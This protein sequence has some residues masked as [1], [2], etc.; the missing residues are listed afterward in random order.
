MPPQPAAV[1]RAARPQRRR[2]QQPPRWLLP[3]QHPQMM[4]YAGSTARRCRT[5]APS[6]RRQGLRHRALQRCP[7]RRRS[8][9]RRP[10]RPLCQQR[11]RV[12]RPRRRRRCGRRFR[13]SPPRRA[14]L[15]TRRR[16]RRWWPRHHSRPPIATRRR[17]HPGWQH[18][19]AASCEQH[20]RR[21][22]QLRVPRLLPPLLAQPR[23]RAPPNRQRPRASR[24]RRG[25]SNGSSS[26]SR[27]RQPPQL[28][29]LPRHLSRRWRYPQRRRLLSLQ[30]H[31][32]RAPR[33]L[34][35][36]LPLP[37]PPRQLA[38]AA[39]LRLPLSRQHKAGRRQSRRR[40]ARRFLA[41]APSRRRG[42][43]RR[44]QR[45][46]PLPPPLV[47][48]QSQARRAARPL[49]PSR[50]PPQLQQPQPGPPAS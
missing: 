12:P 33:R 18:A 32:Q 6:V 45:L 36:S 31:R 25:S 2:R 35:V 23:R 19:L 34:L 43:R 37:A 49:P 16:S 42:S 5:C 13:R 1:P 14:P 41:V 21:A 15:S 24:S 8:S 39:C 30:R 7:P 44:R 26:N 20:R 46:R 10:W 29:L 28:L 27:S 40:R 48:R 9:R 11:L 17:L 22:L 38:P 3:L 50:R 47:R 4:R